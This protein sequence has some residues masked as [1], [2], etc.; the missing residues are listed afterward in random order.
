MTIKILTY[1]LRE[2]WKRLIDLKLRYYV[3]YELA[4]CTCP[5]IGT[6]HL[7]FLLS[8]RRDENPLHFFR[9][10]I[11]PYFF[12]LMSAWLFW[13]DR[14]IFLPLA[15]CTFSLLHSLYLGT[16]LC[17]THLVAY[18]NHFFFLLFPTYVLERSM[19][20]VIKSDRV[21][22]TYAFQM[23]HRVFFCAVA[24]SVVNLAVA[25]YDPT[26]WSSPFFGN[27]P[28]ECM[29]FSNRF[30]CHLVGFVDTYWNNF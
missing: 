6:S 11:P 27:E 21:I 12:L 10:P 19:T 26:G 29:Y 1:L 20:V 4:P 3:Y 23:W 22:P 25:L 30:D 5:R 28:V 17:R 9:D 24:A 8:L 7:S 15:P 16:F 2:F 14:H 13:F 18:E